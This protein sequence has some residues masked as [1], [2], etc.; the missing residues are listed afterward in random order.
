MYGKPCRAD[1][2]GGCGTA[3]VLRVC[4]LVVRVVS[5][6]VRGL[7]MNL[8]EYRAAV[9]ERCRIVLGDMVTYWDEDCDEVCGLYHKRGMSLWACANEC[10]LTITTW[11]FCKAEK[12]ISGMPLERVVGMIRT[13]RHFPR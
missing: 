6:L 7:P 4:L 9:K 10:G 11:A 5:K 12:G 2:G 13:A 3:V 1:P 8:T